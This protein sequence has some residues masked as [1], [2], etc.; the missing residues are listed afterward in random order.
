M[1]YAYSLLTQQSLSSEEPLYL[2]DSVDPQH[3]IQLCYG[4]IFKGMC[5]ELSITDRQS[6]PISLQFEEA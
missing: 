4:W 5:K 2:V 1:N 3:Q 6:I